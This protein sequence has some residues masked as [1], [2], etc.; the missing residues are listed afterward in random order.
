MSNKYLKNI[1]FLS[2]VFLF[3][4]TV[5]SLAA[6]KNAIADTLAVAQTGHV[7][8]LPELYMVLP[9]IILLL[10]IATGPLFY[11]HF[12]EKHYPKISIE[13]FG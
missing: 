7:T 10:L 12:W 4:G 3:F 13:I 6:D 9:F 8:K 2:I 1:L 11:K 5:N